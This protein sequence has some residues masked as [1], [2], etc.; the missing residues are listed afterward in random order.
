MTTRALALALT[1][2]ALVTLALTLTLTLTLTRCE[3]GD[4]EGLWSL[5]RKAQREEATDGSLNSAGGTPLRPRTPVTG[6]LEAQASLEPQASLETQ[7][8]ARYYTR[9]CPCKANTA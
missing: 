6:L 2:R 3:I 7:P 9:A 1:L 8:Q 4:H 5:L